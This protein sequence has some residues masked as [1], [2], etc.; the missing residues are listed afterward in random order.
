[1]PKTAAITAML[2]KEPE[3]SRLAD[4][5]AK[6]GRQGQQNPAGARTSGL[7][8]DELRQRSAHR[9][10]EPCWWSPVPKAAANARYSAGM[11]G[12]GLKRGVSRRKAT[13]RTAWYLSLKPYWGKP[14]VRNFRG[15]LETRV[16]VGRGNRSAIERAESGNSRPKA[17]HAS[18]LP[19]K[20]DET[21]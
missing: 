21:R 2:G 9:G 10:G 15:R 11:S 1:M 13:D 17:A 4:E 7:R 14:T 16:M 20:G 19:D 8:G 5:V 12:I 3:V 6:R 18:A